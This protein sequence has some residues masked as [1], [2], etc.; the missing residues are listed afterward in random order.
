MAGASRRNRAKTAELV[1]D[2]EGEPETPQ[3]RQENSGTHSEIS[4]NSPEKDTSRPTDSHSGTTVGPAN[5]K[6]KLPIRESPSNPEVPPSRGAPT[7]PRPQPITGVDPTRAYLTDLYKELRQAKRSGNPEDIAELEEHIAMIRGDLGMNTG[8]ARNT[9]MPDTGDERK[10]IAN[11]MKSKDVP[12]LGSKSRAPTTTQL[13]RWIRDMNNQFKLCWATEDSVQR[14][15]FSITQ[16]KY[17]P[18]HDIVDRAV[19][20]DRTIT[21]WKELLTRLRSLVED[22]VLTRYQNYEKFWS[23]EWR[24]GQSFTEFFNFLTNVESRLEERPFNGEMSGDLLKIS[25]VWS[26]MPEHLRVEMRRA[27][28]LKSVNTWE[29]FERALRDAE[30]AVGATQGPGTSQATPGQ[31]PSGQAQQRS[32]GKRPASQT[33]TGSKGNNRSSKK[34]DRRPSGGRQRSTSPKPGLSGKESSHPQGKEGNRREHWKNRNKDS[35]EQQGN[36]KP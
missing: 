24:D 2:S 17:E 32:G 1:P 6:G 35:E 12:T 28:Q 31:A 3:I 29:A 4:R 21:S 16:I 20:D 22:P 36:G 10:G 14:V 26:R 27:G 15:M 25:F 34:Q 5:A 8:P 18:F 19:N 23:V 9:P 30:T 33:T 7:P 13:D 11:L